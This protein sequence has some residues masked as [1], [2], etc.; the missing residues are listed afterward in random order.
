MTCSRRSRCA[1][2]A[3]TSS[4]RSRHGSCRPA[5]RSKS[6]LSPT[7]RDGRTKARRSS[8]TDGID[9]IYTLLRCR[10][11]RSAGGRG[12][13]THRRCPALI[14]PTAAGWPAC[15]R[16][17]CS[18]W[19]CVLFSPSPTLPGSPRSASHGMTRGSGLTTR[20]TR[21]CSGSGNWTSGTRCSCRPCSRASSYLSFSV[22]GVGLWQARLVSVVAG[23]AATA[24]L[25]LGLRAIATQAVALAGA[26]LLA[27]NFTWVMYSRVALLEAT[28]VAFLVASW[29]CYARAE[30]DWRWGLGAAGFGLLA[31][32]TKASAAF[33]LIATRPGLR[34]GWAGA[35]GAPGAAS[36][37]PQC[38]GARGNVCRARR[39]HAGTAGGVRGAPVGAVL[40]LQ[41]LSCT[42]PGAR[43]WAPVRCWIA[44]RGSRSSTGSSHDSGCS[45]R[46][47]GRAGG[48]ARAVSSC[49]GRR[50]RSGAVVRAGR[51]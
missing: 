33:F 46:I 22:F 18:R 13:A 41:P 37:A 28:M 29:A 8:W 19:R 23:L 14:D 24:A 2:W 39:G 40:L 12:T 6:C 20:G 26:W 49:L 30:R 35:R 44:P 36:E 10:V 42:G 21:R 25:A 11:V 38:A 16:R 34:A 51:V 9:A 15:W 31:F 32:F 50:A 5:S 43:R 48:G 27:V 47:A 17:C 3:S 4:P 1:A 7:T 45:V